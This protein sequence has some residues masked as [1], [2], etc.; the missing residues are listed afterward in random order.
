MCIYSLFFGAITW[1]FVSLLVLIPS[2][3]KDPPIDAHRME[4]RVLGYTSWLLL[5]F[6]TSHSL[7]KRCHLPPMLY[8]TVVNEI[9]SREW[10]YNLRISVTMMMH[11]NLMT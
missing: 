7:G 2:C 3:L 9:S 6:T 5:A 8:V 1:V 4:T 10:T 11:G